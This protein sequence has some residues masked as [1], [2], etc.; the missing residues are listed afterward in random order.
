[1]IGQV[2]LFVCYT[3]CDSQSTKS[4]LIFMTLSTDDQH[5]RQISLTFE[6]SRS[7]FKVK[8]AVLKTFQFVVL[9]SPLRM[10]IS[11]VKLL[12]PVHVTPS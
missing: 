4:S 8:T 12:V 11:D 9:C 1:M 7:K 6:T 10:F 2:C 3:H 5:L